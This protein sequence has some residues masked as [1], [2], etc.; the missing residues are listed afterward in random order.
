MASLVGKRFEFEGVEGVIVRPD[1]RHG[2]T[3]RGVRCMAG[4]G[5]CKA[6]E[7]ALGHGCGTI[8]DGVMYV[9]V[10]DY[11]KVQVGGI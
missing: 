6:I 3:Y 8:G 11:I 1:E 5:Q 2:C 10:L 7:I 4:L 9:S